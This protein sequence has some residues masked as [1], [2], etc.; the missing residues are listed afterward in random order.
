MKPDFAQFEQRYKSRI[1]II[2]VDVSQQEVATKYRQYKESQY[3]PETVFLKNGEVKYRQTGA[4]SLPGLEEGLA[5][6][7]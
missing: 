6:T 5:K 7:L 4:M 1:T 3:I 2:P